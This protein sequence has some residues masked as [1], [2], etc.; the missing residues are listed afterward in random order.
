MEPVL[1]PHTTHWLSGIDVPAFREH[2]AQ[3]TGSHRRP[4]GDEDVYS[5]ENKSSSLDQIFV[6]N[7]ILN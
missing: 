2:R 1:L 6:V 3:G 7:V 5:F 4:V